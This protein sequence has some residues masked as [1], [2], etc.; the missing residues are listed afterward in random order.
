MTWSS[1]NWGQNVCMENQNRNFVVNQ[2][3]LYSNPASASFKKK[4]IEL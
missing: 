4:K 2:L 3:D 1:Q